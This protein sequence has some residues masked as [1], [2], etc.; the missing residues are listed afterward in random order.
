MCEYNIQTIFYRFS[1]HDSGHYHRMTEV[2]GTRNGTI[3]KSSVPRAY[4]CFEEFPSG[5]F[6][7]EKFLQFQTH[8]CEV[9]KKTKCS[10]LTQIA[11]LHI[12]FGFFLLAFLTK[13]YSLFD[14][15]RHKYI[16]T[17]AHNEI[18]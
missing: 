18:D 8:S 11:T 17:F 2:Q 13:I 16:R 6:E 12:P 7:L 5:G 15:S 4:D 9:I 3:R 10:D 14:C 1:I